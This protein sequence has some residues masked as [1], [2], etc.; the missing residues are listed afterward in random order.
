MGGFG[1]LGMLPR[2]RWT[3]RWEPAW[4]GCGTAG[5]KL[6]SGSTDPDRVARPKEIYIREELG[7][8]SS[9]EVIAGDDSK[10]IIELQALRSLPTS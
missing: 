3:M 6:S 1:H 4:L 9:I 5:P 10:Q 2:S 7:M 8:L